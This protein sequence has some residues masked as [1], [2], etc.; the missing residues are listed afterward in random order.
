MRRGGSHLEF[1][2]IDTETTGMNPYRGAKLIEVAGVRVKN[3]ELCRDDFFDSLIDP[4]CI[5]PIAITALTG[6]SNLTVKGKSTVC[7]VLR[8]FY[9]FAGDATLIIHNAPF[10][11]SF[12]N[13]YGDKCGLG[14][15][16]NQFIDT[17][18][19]SKAVFRYGRNNL[20]ILLARLGII[21][22]S[23]HRALGDAL[24]TA[25]AFVAM[26]NRIGTNN[27]TRFIKKPNI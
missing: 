3:W 26:L 7:D 18:E 5:I 4:E 22:E 21:P 2:V 24:A 1:V 19:V 9:S 12:I 16:R 11:L 13:F 23:R 15:L 27:V 10:D 6:I 14:K 17:I 8:G 25:E 20:D